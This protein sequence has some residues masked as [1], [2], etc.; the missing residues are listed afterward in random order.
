MIEALYRQLPAESGQHSQAVASHADPP[1]LAATEESN[2]PNPG[3]PEM[4]IVPRPL[5]AVLA[6]NMPVAAGP[7]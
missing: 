3:A 5:A 4:V 2:C 6:G 7:S 1:I